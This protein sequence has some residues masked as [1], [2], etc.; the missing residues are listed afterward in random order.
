MLEELVTSVLLSESL[1]KKGVDVTVLTRRVPGL[2]AYSEVRGIPEG[3]DSISPNRHREIDSLEDLLDMIGHL[4]EVSGL[5]TG[6]KAVVGSVDWLEALCALI[7]ERGIE[8]AP[9]FDF[10]RRTLGRPRLA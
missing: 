5:P 6:F 4:R 2:P 3:E 9:D 8:S 1:A 10:L 7:H